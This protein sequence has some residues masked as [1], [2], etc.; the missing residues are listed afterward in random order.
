M[1]DTIVRV[2]AVA[3]VHC[4]RAGQGALAPLFAQMAARADVLLLCGDLTDTGHPDE[5]RVLVGELAVAGRVPVVAVLGNHDYEVDATGELG[6]ILA[7]AGVML[8]DGDACV[9]RGVGFAGVKGFGGGF[10]AAA[11]PAW[12]EPMV[13]AFVQEARREA[14]KLAH[15]ERI[16]SA[17]AGEGGAELAQKGGNA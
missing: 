9:I 8:L 6:A 2:A 17:A 16:S 3:D 4:T 14:G 7:E 10:G 12:G 15:C 11:L 1:T 13:K 5:A